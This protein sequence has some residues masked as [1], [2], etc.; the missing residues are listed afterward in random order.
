MD[1]AAVAQKGKKMERNPVLEVLD[2]LW[3]EVHA[4]EQ[5][6]RLAATRQVGEKAWVS[7]GRASMAQDIRELLDRY[8]REEQDSADK[9]Q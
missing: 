8:I 9:M 2:E 3:T 4:H 7:H 5:A 1:A 6:E